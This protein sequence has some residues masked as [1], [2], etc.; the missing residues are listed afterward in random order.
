MSLLDSSRQGRSFPE[1]GLPSAEISRRLAELKASLTS[2]VHGAFS[3]HCL[4]DGDRYM[5]ESRRLGDE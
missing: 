5:P 4:A 1:R 3:M 2:D